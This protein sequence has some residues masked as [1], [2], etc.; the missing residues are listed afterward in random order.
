MQK[1]NTGMK[2]REHRAKIMW[3]E[4]QAER[5]LPSFSKTTDPAWTENSVPEKDEGW[6]LACRFD[7][8]PSQQGNPSVANVQFLVD[9]A[10][11]GLL[12]AGARLRLFERAT[13]QYAAVEI[14]D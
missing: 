6:S 11:H 9:E 14:L 7:R 5:G 4:K 10:P 1:Q 3:S 12:V 8:P 2:R 13:D